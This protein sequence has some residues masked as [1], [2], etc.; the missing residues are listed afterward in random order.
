M[1]IK[2]YVIGKNDGEP[3]QFI[4]KSD[5]YAHDLKYLLA[6]FDEACKDFPNLNFQDISVKVYNDDCWGKQTGIEFRQPI[7]VEIPS[8]YIELGKLPYTYN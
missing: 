2:K 7:G 4:I 5:T 6:L 3:P 1:Q 8:I